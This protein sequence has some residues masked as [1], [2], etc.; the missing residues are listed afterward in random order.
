MSLVYRLLF[1]VQLVRAVAP[2]PTPP[3][4]CAC[5]AASHGA[6]ARRIREDGVLLVQRSVTGNVLHHSGGTAIAEN[7]TGAEAP[8][9][10]AGTS[11][12]PQRRTSPGRPE[13][14]SNIRVIGQLVRFGGGGQANRSR[15]CQDFP[16][17]CAPPFTCENRDTA[18]KPHRAARLATEE[19]RANI[20]SWCDYGPGYIRYAQQCAAGNMFHA[21]QELRK[22]QSERRRPDGSYPLLTM[23]AAYCF[24][25]GHCNDTAVT[26]HTTI[27]Q[28]EAMCDA[29]YTRRAWT[30][31]RPIA[32]AASPKRRGVDS[33]WAKVAC[34]MGTFHCDI[35]YC[36]IYY[37][38]DAEWK[39]RFGY[40]AQDMGHDHHGSRNR[41]K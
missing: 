14:S 20:H 19:G 1:I 34:A 21:A 17:T 7:G 16:G 5:R 8:P 31:V 39:A 22:V 9:P 13:V 28:A 40:L 33:S 32:M 24:A 26:L 2:R 30:G 37:C 18:R 35:V 41:A 4:C 36:R 38:K 15:D 6:G 10:L 3:S 29:R 25:A 12:V 27:L 23:D 11:R